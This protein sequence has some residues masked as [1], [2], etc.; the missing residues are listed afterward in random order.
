MMNALRIMVKTGFR[1]KVGLTDDADNNIDIAELIPAI[2]DGLRD[3]LSISTIGDNN[4]IAGF[5]G[6]GGF[7]RRD[8]F[9]FVFFLPPHFFIPSLS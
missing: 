1:L 8:E 7:F 4:S 3:D 2:G 9:L 6:F 5:D